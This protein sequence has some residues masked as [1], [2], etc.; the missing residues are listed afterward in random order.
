MRPRN[1]IA[2]SDGRG[3]GEFMGAAWIWKEWCETLFWDSKGKA[4][5]RTT[6]LQDA[7][8]RRG[9]IE[10]P[11]GLGVRQSSAAL[12]TRTR[13]K[14]GETFW[15][16]G[17]ERHLPFWSRI[18]FIC[19]LHFCNVE[20]IYGLYLRKRC[21]PFKPTR[22]TPRILIRDRDQPMFHRVLVGIVEP[23]KVRYLVREPS[24]PIVKP[25]LTTWVLIEVVYKFWSLH[26][27]CFHHRR[28]TLCV[29][30]Q[31]WGLRDKVI[32]IGEHGP[33]LEMPV[34]IV[35]YRQQA[36]MELT[37]ALRT[38][39]MVRLLVGA[40]RDKIRAAVRKLMR[41]RVRPWCPWYRHGALTI[42]PHPS[43]AMSF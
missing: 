36:V 21:C 38:P 31:S 30:I 39:E 28:Q 40:S 35:G 1:F 29:F 24:L 18:E 26:M 34:E 43:C 14:T 27:Q 32:V 2:K 4:V 42:T 25:D 7:S 16:R 37:Q 13:T 20:S 12:T 11:P 8:R 17:T 22:G 23:G 5:E 41:R 3:L 15:E 33:C 10:L 6:A 9:P 19:H